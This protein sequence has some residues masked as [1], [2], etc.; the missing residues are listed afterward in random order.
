MRMRKR[1]RSGLERLEWWEQ[2][3]LC[4]GQSHGMIFRGGLVFL[5]GGRPHRAEAVARLCP[6]QCRGAERRKNLQCTHSEM[7]GMFV[8]AQTVCKTTSSVRQSVPKV[9]LLVHR[10][11]MTCTSGIELLLSVYSPTGHKTL[12]PSLVQGFSNAIHPLSVN[13]PSPIPSTMG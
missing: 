5:K 13:P 4:C 7:G 12:F 1:M 9:N 3:T 2:E 8:P 11:W 10:P 6:Q